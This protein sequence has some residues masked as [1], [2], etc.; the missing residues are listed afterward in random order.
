M[1]LLSKIQFNA[2]IYVSNS[3]Y[4]VMQKRKNEDYYTVY[5]SQSINKDYCKYLIWKKQLSSDKTVLI[6]F[7]IHDIDIVESNSNKY[8]Y[9][10]FIQKYAEISNVQ[11]IQVFLQTFHLINIDETSIIYL[12]QLQIE[13]IFDTNFIP[14]VTAIPVKYKVIDIKQPK[15]IIHKISDKFRNYFLNQMNLEFKNRSSIIF[16]QPFITDED[17][18]F[19]VKK[20]IQYSVE[21]LDDKTI[22]INLSCTN[23][24]R[25]V[26]SVDKLNLTEPIDHNQHRLVNIKTGI[27]VHKKI[28]KVTDIPDPEN[29]FE[30][31]DSSDAFLQMYENIRFSKQKFWFEQ[32]NLLDTVSLIDHLLQNSN[33][34]SQIVSFE[35][36][37]KIKYRY[38]IIRRF[39][40]YIFANGQLHHTVPKGLHDSGVLKKPENLRLKLI[41]SSYQLSL[42]RLPKIIENINARLRFL[43]KDY[44]SP[45]DENDCIVFDYS[46]FDHEFLISQIRDY[47][48]FSYL[49]HLLDSHNMTVKFNIPRDTIDCVNKKVKEA[50]K[51]NALKFDFFNDFDENNIANVLLK[52]GIKNQAVPWKIKDIEQDINHIFVGI[53]LGHNHNKGSSNLSITAVD[54]YGC[55]LLRPYIKRN[56]KANEVIPYDELING[57]KWILKKLPNYIQKITIHRDGLINQEEL[58]SFHQVMK[59]FDITQYNLVE[60]VKSGVPRIGFYSNFN[61]E[62]IYLDGFMGYYIF[63]DTPIEISYLITNDQCLKN[64]ILP[65]PIKIKKVY[66]YK[67]ITKI[68]EE[69]YWLTKAYSN[70]IFNPTQ[71][72]I[73]TQIANNSSYSKNL[74]HF[75]TA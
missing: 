35:D 34:K 11:S 39:R 48:Q 54:N 65:K 3:N 1:L 61:N 17:D 37:N 70:N 42:N 27:S 60:V 22:W 30:S 18:K 9:K 26:D 46:N 40:N 55:L 2:I 13:N 56:I 47:S 72:P 10:L 38:K 44:V 25:T 36:I 41:I 49:V 23:F 52:L 68:T 19:I 73:T 28:Q 75:T 69:I 67:K 21:F 15:E 29:V 33:E 51:T 7:L 8:K 71:L 45:I 53:D 59:Y 63:I 16:Q 50:L 43:Y 66:G 31:F 6:F 32:I 62:N 64:G 58:N 4:E 14:F 12:H 57:F 24:S 20:G 5:L 74:I